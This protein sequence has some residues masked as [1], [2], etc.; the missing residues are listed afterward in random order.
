MA[1]ILSRVISDKAFGRRR[2]GG[3]R[4]KATGG[5][6]TIFGDYAIHVFTS[7]GT[8]IITEPSLNQVEYIVQA[9]GGGGG[10]VLSPAASRVGGGGAGGY[11]TGTMPISG[12]QPVTV[13]SGGPSQNPG[14]PS[15]FGPISATGG[16]RGGDAG[17]TGGFDPVMY[18]GPG[19]C[20]GSA[21]YSFIGPPCTL[22]TGGWG[23]GNVGGYTPPEGGNGSG[24]ST[25]T[26]PG[27]NGPY[28][29]AGGI[30]GNAPFERGG[31][32]LQVPVT[33][34]IPTIGVPS[35][36]GSNYIGGG[37]GCGG[38]PGDNSCFFGPQP[39]HLPG[40]FGGGGNGGTPGSNG[41]P[42]T[43]NTGGGGG[44][45]GSSTGGSGGPGIVA[46][47]YFAR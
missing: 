38:G 26:T 17:P 10:I 40:G 32:G 42:G 11:R 33:F 14:N 2:G 18:G 43:T 31:D 7:P 35:P 23:S 30:S 15:S 47:A 45:S 5:T 3:P 12:P 9:G 6:A 21:G 46:V 16:G 37:G 1:P 39:H 24:G 41:S 22:T 25:P 28:G 13:G 36:L 20:G 34:R 8:F 19:G 27:N 44:G 4:F 29:F